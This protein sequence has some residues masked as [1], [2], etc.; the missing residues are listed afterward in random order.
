MS[1]PYDGK[2]IPFDKRA[3]RAEKIG[4]NDNTPLPHGNNGV[5]PVTEGFH[6][7]VPSHM[8]V[9][10]VL[11]YV[12]QEFKAGRVAA[13]GIAIVIHVREK[14]GFPGSVLYYSGN[15]SRIELIGLMTDVATDAARADSRSP[16]GD[17]GSA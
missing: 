5:P 12:Q 15:L 11:D 17:D 4:A 14:I 2:V 13:D 1:D 7:R 9:M 3:R 8:T 6:E 16:Q 10:N